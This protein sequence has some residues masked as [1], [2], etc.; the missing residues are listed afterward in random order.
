MLVPEFRTAGDAGLGTVAHGSG[1]LLG[2]LKLIPGITE[3]QVIALRLISINYR[4]F[5]RVIRRH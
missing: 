2:S 4:I 3:A 5:R 1:T